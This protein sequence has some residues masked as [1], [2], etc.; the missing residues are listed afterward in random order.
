MRQTLDRFADRLI[1]RAV[2]WPAIIL[3]VMDLAPH[4]VNCQGKAHI[5]P[6]IED[7][8]SMVLNFDNGCFG[9]IQSSWL[10]PNKIRE[11]T[12]VGS[13]RMLVYNDSE[14]TEKIKIYDKRV[15][16]PPYYETFEEYLINPLRLIAQSFH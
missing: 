11:M 12:F 10:D 16:T 13:N 4:S 2:F 3:Y 1:D 15:E 8:T 14:P 6:E 7:V 5:N 9:T